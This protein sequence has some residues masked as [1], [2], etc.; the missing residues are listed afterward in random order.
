MPQ[1]AHRPQAL[2]PCVMRLAATL[3]GRPFSEKAPI[4]G[5]FVAHSTQA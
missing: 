4:Q 5:L 2:R 3:A 1:F